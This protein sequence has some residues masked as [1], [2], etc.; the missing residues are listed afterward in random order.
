MSVNLRCTIHRGSVL[1][2]G[3]AVD[4]RVVSERTARQRILSSASSG[5]DVFRIHDLLVA[6]FAEPAR[7]ICE[8]APGYPL[9]RYG[10]LLSSAPLEAK[11]VAA[12]HSDG[13]A[14]V[15]VRDG[16]ALVKELVQ[17]DKDA[18]VRI[19][20][21]D[22][23]DLATFDRPAGPLESVRTKTLSAVLRSGTTETDARKPLGAPPLS[24]EAAVIMSSILA[25]GGG[26]ARA[27][28]TS[29]SSARHRAAPGAF[30]RFV[31]RLLSVLARDRRGS[32]RSE[33]AATAKASAPGQQLG[34]ALPPKQS[35]FDRLSDALQRA[36]AQMLIWANATS[37]VTRKRAAHLARTMELFEK[38]DFDA[39]LRHAIPLSKEI[40]EALRLPPPALRAPSV[41]NNLD[42]VPARGAAAG[43]LGLSEDLFAA[44]QRV[45]RKAF[46]RLVATGEIEKAAFVLAELLQSD[47]EAVSF[48]ER[49][50]RL[51][52]AAEIAEARGL[53]P[54][55]IVRQWFLAGDTERAIRIA[56]CTGSFAD[57]VTRLSS[58]HQQAAESLR[59]LWADH[60]ASSGAYAAAVHAIWPAKG[61][62]PLESARR[63]A[64]EWIERALEIGGPQSGSML[65]RRVMARPEALTDSFERVAKLLDAEPRGQKQALSIAEEIRS[66]PV[67]PELKS[68]AKFVARTVSDPDSELLSDLI[69]YSRDAALRADFQACNEKQAA[70]PR[71]YVQATGRLVAPDP[72]HARGAVVATL[73][74]PLAQRGESVEGWVGANGL[75]L[76]VFRAADWDHRDCAAIAARAF[77]TLVEH[78]RVNVAPV[79]EAGIALEGVLLE[80]NRQLREQ[81]QIE[82]DGEFTTLWCA[83]VAVVSGTA[84]VLGHVGDTRAYLL[85]GGRLKQLTTDHTLATE[86][87]ASGHALPPEEAK[88]LGGIVARM[89]GGKDDVSVD[90]VSVDLQT[91][92]LL[93]LGSRAVCEEI[94]D[95]QI[96]RALGR[97][98]TTGAIDALASA[99]SERGR[100]FSTNFLVA[101][102]TGPDLLRF[103]SGVPATAK[104]IVITPE[105]RATVRFGS[106]LREC[107]RIE[108]AATDTG[109]ISVRDVALLP[110]GRMLVALGE[111]GVWLLSP[112]G[113]VLT[114]FAQPAH[115]IVISDHGDRAILVA[116]RGAACRLARLDLRTKRVRPWCDAIVDDFARTFDGDVWYVVHVLEGG[117]E[118]DAISSIDCHSD[119]WESIART[120][121]SGSIQSIS[122]DSISMSL[123]VDGS[124]GDELWIYEMPA[125]VLRA[126]A[127][128]EIGNLARFNA[129][130]I[131]GL[132]CS[133]NGRMGVGWLVPDGETAEQYAVVVTDDG[134]WTEVARV[135][136]MT[137]AVATNDWIVFAS[138]QRD[139]MFVRVHVLDAVS[140]KERLL[141]QFGR[142]HPLVGTGIRLRIQG[143]CLLICDNLGRV[144]VVSLE[145]GAVVQEH[146]I[147]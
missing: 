45:Y 145:D 90:V 83:T 138:Q 70:I 84:L 13:D 80:V 129:T 106:P 105:E 49:H 79:H 15:L 16:V 30:R 72:K 53:A 97:G 127:S 104:A 1:A 7:Y 75:A 102:F 18:V 120:P 139:D 34:P 6:R 63:L 48:L 68:L 124:P 27:A 86:A 112:T 54:G 4:L 23:L 58:S 56:R 17:Q 41:R 67:T 140:K 85:R 36:A 59:L 137:D 2:S 91:G 52:L 121:T 125:L 123:N 118:G 147:S 46:D 28:S 60:L 65:V 37:L 109:S 10:R 25:G 51:K 110:D 62:W 11:E 71:V 21:A 55:L 77:T 98:S 14:L 88:S 19:D 101:K 89:F 103:G 99:L 134:E 31:G 73:F 119:G 12:I 20:L 35:L 87:A 44:L 111:V 117:H 113:K 130:R 47:A 76:G 69:T 146:R 114:R 93:F 33:G 94:S 100:P 92:D 135:E 133:P 95:L 32:V 66:L 107:V 29:T 132:R 116:S 126:R 40:G 82:E 8:T 122:R 142:S 136:T 42:I 5:L 9:V 108:R 38:R 96:A 143:N 39:A 50:G 22:W 141:I 128:A 74:D 24:A 43:S 81:R 26:N 78:A 61:A 64:V 115:H 131:A 144:M 3:F 57:A